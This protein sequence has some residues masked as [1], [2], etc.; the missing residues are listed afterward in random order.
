MHALAGTREAALVDNANQRVQE[1][2]IKHERLAS[3]FAMQ[4]TL[5]G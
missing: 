4:L 5:R 3:L 1:I 2:E